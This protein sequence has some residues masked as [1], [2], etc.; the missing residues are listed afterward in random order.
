MEKIESLYFK[1]NSIDINDTEYEIMSDF[2]D[3]I[4]SKLNKIIQNKG[5]INKIE[6][7]Y[8]EHF[9]SYLTPQYQNLV[10]NISEYLKTFTYNPNTQIVPFSDNDPRWLYAALVELNTFYIPRS[11]YYISPD[12]NK[13]YTYKISGNRIAIVG[14]Y[15]SADK[16]QQMV[17]KAISQ[18]KPDL[19]IHLGDI[20]VAGTPNECKN[21]WETYTSSFDGKV[22][23]LWC[24]IGNH[25]YIS[26]GKGFFKNLIK[27]KL[28]GGGKQ[29][30][31]YFCLENDELKIQILG[32]DTGY[33]STNFT[34]PVGGEE[35]DYST[36]LDEAQLD[37]VQ[38]KL[39]F[40]KNN[41]YKTIILS[42]HQYISTYWK[43]QQ[44]N[45]K[46]GE[47]IFSVDH[48]IEAWIFG[49]DHRSIIY[50]NPYGNVKNLMCLGHGSMSV[51]VGSYDGYSNN[52]EFYQ[53]LVPNSVTQ[54]NQ[55]IYNN[56]FVIM[57][58]NLKLEIYEVDRNTEASNLYG[59]LS[60]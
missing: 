28:L 35:M 8:H 5:I 50:K 57:D 41:E 55:N 44:F 13:D 46:L 11:K 2:I 39:T 7:I 40:A 47:Q 36:Y 54:Y 26:K 14:D 17:T 4:T 19:I 10:E 53:N 31:S 9:D 27:P 37:W 42:H 24:V 21:F 15:G 16:Y 6:K 1:I 45:T 22:P 12:K 59:F 33:N 32:I 49:H 29:E 58:K 52:F 18:E 51:S 23:P 34:F 25:E 60:L 3:L 38:R 48:P 20:Y 30:A 43:D 56:G